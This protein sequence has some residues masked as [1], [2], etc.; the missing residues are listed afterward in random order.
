MRESS[1]I[2]RKYNEKEVARLPNI[3]S[4]K[5]RVSV[6]EHKTAA[7]R[8]AK[9]SLKT[10]IKKVL[11]LTAEGDASASS[12]Y[13]DAQKNIDKAAASGLLHKKTAARRKSRLARAVKAAQ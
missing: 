4:A 8:M 10:N 1:T 12:A 7:N 2:L 5:K 13:I 3:K 6:T 9:S 11:V